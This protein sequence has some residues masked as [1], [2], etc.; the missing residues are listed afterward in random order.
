MTVSSVIN[1]RAVLTALPKI[2]LHRHLEGSVRLQT[3]VDVAQQYKIE[4]PATDLEGLRAYVQIMPDSPMDSVHFLSKFNLLRRFYYSQ[5]VIERVAREAV[6]DAVADNVKYMELRFT[7]KALSKLMD[8]SFGDVVKWVCTAVKQAQVNTDIKVR[9]IVS[10]NR[11]EGANDGERALNA[12]LD[13]RNQGIVGIDLAGQESGY[14]AVPFYPLFDRAKQAG[15]GITVHAGEWAGPGNI[16]DA[17][18]MMGAQRIGH[19]VRIVEDSVIAGLA[20]ERGTTF[21]V[22]PTS[23]IQSGAV[24]GVANHPLRDMASLGLRTTINTDDPSVSNIK[25]SDELV[26]ANEQL[27]LTLEDIK[28]TIMNA[29][30]CAFLPEAERAALVTY[31]SDA[32]TPNSHSQTL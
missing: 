16:R 8:F 17:I 20:R 7:P 12:A 23:N 28:R 21:E 31:F 3:L 14:G 30:Q 24:A 25:L 6:E 11:H 27:G 26:L 15:L 29:A 2:E 13:F 10:M 19:G 18:T 9:L 22:C 1:S 32:L 5:E 4:L